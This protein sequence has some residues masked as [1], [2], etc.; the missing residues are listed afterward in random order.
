[1]GTYGMP[2]IGMYREEDPDPAK[3]CEHFT[4]TG[5]TFVDS[6]TDKQDKLHEK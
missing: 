3:E 2:H 5:I 6:G 4:L 1:M